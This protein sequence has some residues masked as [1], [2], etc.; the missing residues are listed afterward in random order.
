MIK[1][2]RAYQYAK[3]CGL[4]GNRKVGKYIKKQAKAWL[5][6]AD[7]KHKKAYVNEQSVGKVL[8]LL[9]LMV[10]PDLQIPMDEGLED[11]AHF[12]IIAVFCTR[13]RDDN[14]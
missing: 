6:I 13:T 10:H 2:S 9:R 3:W 14:R 12:L 8:R 1:E 11:Y 4:S 7:G 5:K